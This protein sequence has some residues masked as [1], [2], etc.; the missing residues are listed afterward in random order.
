EEQHRTPVLPSGNHGPAHGKSYSPRNH[1]GRRGKQSAQGMAPRVMGMDQI[2]LSR[3]ARDPQRAQYIAG[4]M[5][6]AGAAQQNRTSP[7]EQQRLVSPFQQPPVQ[8][9][10]LPLTPAHVA[11]VVE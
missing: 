1:H 2:E 8:T 6:H 10:R 7:R 4:K 3:K 11:A 5:L 9:Q